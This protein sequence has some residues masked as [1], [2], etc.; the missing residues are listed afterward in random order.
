[1]KI[2]VYVEWKITAIKIYS[3][4]AMQ[5]QAEQS[6]WRWVIDAW[7]KKTSKSNE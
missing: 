2:T 5:W 1:M 3:Y 7:W 4:R 6:E